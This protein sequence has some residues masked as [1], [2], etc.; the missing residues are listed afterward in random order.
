MN[1]LRRLLV[2]HLTGRTNYTVAFFQYSAISEDNNVEMCINELASRLGAMVMDNE[3]YRNDPEG[4]PSQSQ[5]LTP[6]IKK[7]HIPDDARNAC[8]TPEA[9]VMRVS[10]SPSAVRTFSWQGVAQYQ[11]L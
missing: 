1:A 2:V 8:G 5:C 4:N 7:L 9:H 10:T 11:C 3:F 6:H